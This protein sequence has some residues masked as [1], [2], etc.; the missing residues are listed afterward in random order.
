MANPV[1]EHSIAK[2]LQI[3]K[4]YVGLATK[5]VSQWLMWRIGDWAGEHKTMARS[6]EK[7][8][9]AEKTSKQSWQTKRGECGRKISNKPRVVNTA[10]T[11]GETLST[12]QRS[13]SDAWFARL[14]AHAFS[15]FCVKANSMILNVLHVCKNHGHNYLVP[16][17]LHICSAV[18]YQV[19]NQVHDLKR[20]LLQP[21][22]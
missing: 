20:N 17:V 15:F 16:S 10:S 1:K 18:V 11:Q 6:W 5:L 7:G 3:C 12:P 8:K 4:S 13:L 2:R 14:L 22:A 21:L 19:Q 9:V